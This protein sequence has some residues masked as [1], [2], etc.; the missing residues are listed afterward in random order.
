[1]FGPYYDLSKTELRVSGSSLPPMMAEQG[2]DK[3]YFGLSKTELGLLGP[4]LP[5]IIA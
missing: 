3:P 5:S 2:R 4:S 1:M